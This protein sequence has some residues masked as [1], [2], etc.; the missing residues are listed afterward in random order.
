MTLVTRHFNSMGLSQLVCEGESL[1]GS[2][3]L[4]RFTVIA[5][6]SQAATVVGG[7]E[8]DHMDW[9]AWCRSMHALILRVVRS[10]ARRQPFFATPVW[11]LPSWCVQSSEMHAGL[12]PVPMQ[13]RFRW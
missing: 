12:S 8:T 5:H 9:E 13:K 4:K 6:T 7:S 11:Q 10:S 1:H 2:W 3:G